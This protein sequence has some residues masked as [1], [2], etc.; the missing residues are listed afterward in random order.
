MI[1]RSLKERIRIDKW[2]EQVSDRRECFPRKDQR[3]TLPQNSHAD[4]PGLRRRLVLTL[5]MSFLTRCGSR[6]AEAVYSRAG[7]RALF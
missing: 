7:S 2:D 5:E 1:M 6:F 3:S 4:N